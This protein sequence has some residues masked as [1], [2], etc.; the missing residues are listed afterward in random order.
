V[1]TQLV[2]GR[3]AGLATV[4]GYPTVTTAPGWH[5]APAFPDPRNSPGNA[6]LGGKL[7]IVGGY[8]GS[9]GGHGVADLWAFDPA[10]NTWTQKTPLPS[11]SWIYYWFECVALNGFLYVKGDYGPFF[12]YDPSTNAWTILPS[13]GGVLGT[14]V[15]STATNRIVSFYYGTY[16][17]YDATT[18][19]W[20][21]GG[22]SPRATYYGW[23]CEYNGVIY[24]FGGS[25][26]IANA[27]SLYTFDPITFVFTAKAS[28]PLARY[29]PAVTIFQDQL[30]AVG[31]QNASTYATTS[32]TQLYDFASNTWSTGTSLPY[33]SYASAGASLAGVRVVAGYG[34]SG[35]LGN[36]ERYVGAPFSGAA[37][38]LLGLEFEPGPYGHSRPELD[39][40]LGGTADIGPTRVP[41]PGRIITG[42]RPPGYI[43]PRRWRD[44][45]N[46]NIPFPAADDP[47]VYV[48]G[49][50]TGETGPLA[51]Q[52]RAPYAMDEYASAT[53]ADGRYLWI[54]GG[55]WR[56][57][58][59]ITVNGNTYVYEFPSWAQWWS[60]RI[61]RFDA[62]MKTWR[63]ETKLPG[64]V[65]SEGGVAARIGDIIYY[66]PGDA[67][68]PP[69]GTPPNDDPEWDTN[70]WTLRSLW[71]YDITAQTWT[72]KARPGFAND[73]GACAT[74]DGKLYAY[75]GVDW[76]TDPQTEAAFYVYDPGADAWT[77][78]AS[79]PTTVNPDYPAMFVSSGQIW[80]IG[81][82][83]PYWIGTP[84]WYFFTY[85]S[86]SDT[87]TDH[88]SEFSTI[89]PA[90]DAGVLVQMS[91]TVIRLIGGSGNGWTDPDLGPLTPYGTM[92][93]IDVAA[94][95]VTLLGKLPPN[96]NMGWGGATLYSGDGTIYT[97]NGQSIATVANP[98]HVL[99][100]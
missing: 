60:N 10:L 61:Y 67:D 59:Q 45:P 77:Q 26:T 21:A 17:V 55:W 3:T 68:D 100:Y 41:S 15:A 8:S 12:R 14:T 75:P 72:R 53:S 9:G 51:G 1:T 11:R 20:I 74:L 23:G 19:T 24:V 73:Y 96:Q 36:H 4:N 57:N 92:I 6:V 93:E 13:G 98:T 5:S 70:S 2:E 63:E 32:D 54:I 31:G 44:V 81:R 79:S 87:W 62:L 18:N 42:T 52:L 16:N 29:Q 58:T 66:L 90:R 33:V 80:L 95:T 35:Y 83:Y 91:D 82:N 37:A 38:L 84:V 49:P 56:D 64:Y 46:T 94:H 34:S 97:P 27:E 69:L 43:D 28:S 30:W 25:N 48:G 99:S 86:G 50:N 22:S 85:D 71:A 7:Y 40:V 65:G 88:T 78:L 47:N 89:I 76:S 39:L